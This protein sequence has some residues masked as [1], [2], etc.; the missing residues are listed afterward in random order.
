MEGS[1]AW[2]SRAWGVAAYTP[3]F[4]T[5]PGYGLCSL[6]PW[7]T[8]E[9]LKILSLQTCFRETREVLKGQVQAWGT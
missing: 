6:E 2:R 4:S 7:G 3:P 9:H 8:W 5:H 1:W